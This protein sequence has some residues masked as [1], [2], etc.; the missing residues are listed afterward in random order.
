MCTTIHHLLSV[1]VIMRFVNTK[2]FNYKVFFLNYLAKVTTTVTKALMMLMVVCVWIMVM[3]MVMILDNNR[4]EGAR[5]NCNIACLATATVGWFLFY[6]A[7]I[8]FCTVR[9][10]CSDGQT[11]TTT[12]SIFK[13][14][15]SYRHATILC[16]W[17]FGIVADSV[18]DGDDGR[19]EEGREYTQNHN[20]PWITSHIAKLTFLWT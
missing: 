11:W 7:Q 10:N 13:K 1:P 18:R 20:I 2:N 8:E 19:G 9:L 6:F 15:V 4:A 5:K 12:R 16:K 17:S 3:A 14:K